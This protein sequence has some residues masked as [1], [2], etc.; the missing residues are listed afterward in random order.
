MSAGV[1]ELKNSVSSSTLLTII[2]GFNP[3][4]SSSRRLDVDAEAKTILGIAYAFFRV[5]KVIL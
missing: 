5:P 3:A 1:I 4:D 2:V